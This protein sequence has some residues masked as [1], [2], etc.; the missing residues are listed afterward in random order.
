MEQDAPNH[1]HPMCEKFGFDEPTR[2]G[3]VAVSIY[4]VTR[5]YGGQEEGGWYYNRH[6]YT[7]YSERIPWDNDAAIQAA[8]H[9]LLSLFDD[10]Q[11][12]R[13]IYSA[14]NDGPEYMAFTEARCGESDDSDQPRPRYE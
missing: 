11:P 7:G 6:A 1:Q 3:C 14:A 9:R 10:D 5:H 8:R 13:G 4:A 2:D 12:S